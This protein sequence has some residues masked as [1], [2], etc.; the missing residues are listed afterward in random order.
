MKIDYGFYPQ[1]K[2]RAF[3]MSYD[4]GHIHDRRLIEIFN[5][6]DIKGTFHLNSG[7]FGQDHI[8]RPDELKEI[9]KG[10]EVSAHTLTHPYMTLLS[11]EMLVHEIMKDRKNLEDLVGYPVRGMSYPFGAFDD[12]VVE[13]ARTLGMEY[14]RTCIDNPYFGIPRDFLMWNPTC[15]HSNAMSKLEHFQN[16][17]P[18]EVMHLFYVWGHSFEFYRDNDNWTPIEEFCKRVSHDENVWYATN[19][20]IKDYITALRGLVFSADR[21]IIYN[22]SGL[23]VWISVDKEPAE[24]K[25][26][27]TLVL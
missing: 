24:I 19:V 4:D 13:S 1:G 14:S 16:P 25:P 6:Y 23:S 2:K 5:K 7:N 9:Y 20:E 22:P 8:V 15:H 27:Q 26:L 21:H 3:T 11:K 17:N 18:W 10:H 12:V